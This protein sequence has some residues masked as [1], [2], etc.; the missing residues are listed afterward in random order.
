MALGSPFGS[1]VW[2]STR[3]GFIDGFIFS[4]C[5]GTG[6]HVRSA[7]RRRE[8]LSCPPWSLPLLTS[9][10]GLVESLTS[11]GRNSLLPH[12]YFFAARAEEICVRKQNFDRPPYSKSHF[13]PLADGGV[14]FSDR[15][16]GLGSVYASLLSEEER[17]HVGPAGQQHSAQRVSKGA[18]ASWRGGGIWWRPSAACLDRPYLAWPTASTATRRVQVA[19]APLVSRQF[20]SL[21]DDAPSV[22]DVGCHGR[23]SA[24]L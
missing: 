16:M 8:F 23:C 12:P 15:H 18:S 4:I 22:R 3:R 14:F 10:T 24:A 7:K 1:L 20:L 21:R 9:P 5:L 17:D 11:N 2:C 19:A 6:R 13:L